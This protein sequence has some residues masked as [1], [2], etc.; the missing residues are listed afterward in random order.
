MEF[1]IAKGSIIFQDVKRLLLDI[2]KLNGG[3]S[4]RCGFFRFVEFMEFIL[5]ELMKGAQRITS[6]SLDLIDLMK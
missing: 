3:N 5:K 4:R 6:F 1:S 2:A